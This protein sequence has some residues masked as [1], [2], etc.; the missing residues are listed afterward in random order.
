MYNKELKRYTTVTKY[1]GR[2]LSDE[3]F[4]NT[5]RDF[6]HNGKR[7]RYDI[8]EIV[9]HK[10][11]DLRKIIENLDSFRFFTSSLLILYDSV[12]SG[13][14]KSHQRSA[15]WDKDRDV[16]K[17]QE[18]CRT[19]NWAD[20][21]REAETKLQDTSRSK[22]WTETQRER[23]NTKI[24]DQSRNRSRCEV[25]R[26][27]NITNTVEENRCNNSWSEPCSEE[28]T[29]NCDQENRLHHHKDL[30]NHPTFHH[31]HSCISSGGKTREQF[32]KSDSEPPYKPKSRFKNKN[33]TKVDVRLIDFAHATHKGMGDPKVYNGP[34]E[35]ILFGVDSLI[36]IFQDIRDTSEK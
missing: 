9:L 6:L 3:A 7:L 30:N 26:E 35:G 24:Q 23:G 21:R 15:D 31:E 34:D 27:H 32:S 29:S 17:S 4:K 8:L 2:Q 10:L 22:S 33:R 12:E 36:K 5:L 25:K 18:Q 28:R 11:K 16:G 20:S 13:F 19:K 1:V 14:S